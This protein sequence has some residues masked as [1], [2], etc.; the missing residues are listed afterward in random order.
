MFFPWGLISMYTCV[1]LT[2]VL[3]TTWICSASVSVHSHAHQQQLLVA[4]LFKMIVKDSH[5]K[6]CYLPSIWITP[7]IS[8]FLHAT[9]SPHYPN[10]PIAVIEAWY[11]PKYVLHILTWHNMTWLSTV[12]LWSGTV[13]LFFFAA[14]P[15]AA[16]IQGWHLVKPADIN[17]S[18][19]RYVQVRRW[20]TTRRC[21]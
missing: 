13:V 18:W 1:P 4:T 17:G 9:A 10:L 8:Y 16:I 11:W 7:A 12:F 20:S 3:P 21:Q 5:T 15:C 2:L 14:R 6:W 19:K